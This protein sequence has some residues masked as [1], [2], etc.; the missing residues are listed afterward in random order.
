MN[1]NTFTQIK[2]DVGVGVSDLIIEPKSQYALL[3]ANLCVYRVTRL[4]SCPPGVS[5]I[6]VCLFL[7][8]RLV[9]VFG[10]SGYGRLP[11]VLPEVIVG[12]RAA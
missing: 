12:Q 5:L 2:A 9:L 1:I 11:A 6:S 4:G 3:V 7:R 8:L 10:L